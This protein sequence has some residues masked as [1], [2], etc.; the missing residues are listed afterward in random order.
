MSR[1]I[2]I[3]ALLVFAGAGPALAEDNEWTRDGLYLAL[4][5]SVAIHTTERVDNRPGISGRC[6]Y[7]FHPHFSGE[8][9]FERIPARDIERGGTNVG[10]LKTVTATANAKGYLLTGRIQPYLLTGIGLM[11]SDLDVK[12]SAGLSGTSDDF[13][14]RFGGG[15]EFY[16]LPEFVLT[17][18][19]NYMLPTGDASDLDHVLVSLG[20]QY[21]F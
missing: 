21:R 3:S 4:L 1:L 9:Q 20:F 17:L 19:S 16:I 12:V 13:L 7:R 11:H 14:A 2:A 18:E 6:G 10:N 8:V 15:V 5:A